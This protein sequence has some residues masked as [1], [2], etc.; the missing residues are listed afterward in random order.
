MRRRDF[1]QGVVCS[2]TAWPSI[3]RAQQTIRRVGWLDE[4]DQGALEA[5]AIRKAMRE[6]LADLGWI[7][8]RNLKIDE[9]FAAADFSRIRAYAA[10]LVALAPDV[11]ITPAAATTRALQQAT[12]TIPIVFAG[13]GD[14]TANGL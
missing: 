9:R 1:V 8:G 2:S 7:E 6:G 14:A 11:L 10:E 3:A 5:Q 4:Y 13:G 12:Q